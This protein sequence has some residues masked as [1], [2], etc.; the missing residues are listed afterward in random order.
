MEKVIK[1]DTNNNTMLP[2]RRT[3]MDK[4]IDAVSKL[5]SFIIDM[6]DDDEVDKLLDQLLIFNEIIEERRRLLDVVTILRALYLD[7]TEEGE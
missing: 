2:R 4:Y 7:E 3:R 1:L 5:E 6:A